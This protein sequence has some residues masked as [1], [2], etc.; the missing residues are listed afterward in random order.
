[1]SS[2][3]PR[4][5]LLLLTLEEYKRN[6]REVLRRVCRHLGVDE[7]FEFADLDLLRHDGAVYQRRTTINNMWME[8]GLHR[9]IGLPYRAMAKIS[10]WVLPATMRESLKRA[11][12]ETD[13]GRFRLNEAERHS[14]IERLAPDLHRL[15]SVYGVDTERYW[16]LSG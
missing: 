12:V 16:N 4:E 7:E 5:S 9:I 15:R 11:V 8:P 3:F 1:M 13:R 14:V 6:G 2:V 10:R